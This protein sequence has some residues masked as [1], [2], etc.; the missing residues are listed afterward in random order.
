MLLNL[1]NVFDSDNVRNGSVIEVTF[2]TLAEGFITSSAAV[3][4]GSDFSLVKP[5]AL[6][7]FRFSGVDAGVG[8]GEACH[9]TWF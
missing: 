7:A 2:L 3:A 5:E 1:L 4:V 8:G 9:I 6:A